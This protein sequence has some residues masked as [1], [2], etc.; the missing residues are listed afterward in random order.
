M[1]VVISNIGLLK[2]HYFAN[3]LVGR[4][5]RGNGQLAC[6]IVYKAKFRKENGM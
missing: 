3:I 4:E 5:I 1:I 2:L 6:G